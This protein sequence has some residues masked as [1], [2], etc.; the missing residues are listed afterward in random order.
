MRGG[1]IC[2]CLVLAGLLA[3]CTPAQPAGTPQV[4]A[5]PDGPLY[6]GDQVSF[7][8]LGPASQGKQDGSIQVAF[9]GGELA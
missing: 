9:Q 3:G 7:E 4:I 8:V 1:F 2:F 6:A 5:H